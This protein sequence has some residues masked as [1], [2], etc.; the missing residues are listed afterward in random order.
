MTD[1]AIAG[2]LSFVLTN[3]TRVIRPQWDN[4]KAFSTFVV[5]LSILLLL[6]WGAEKWD[7]AN[8]VWDAVVRLFTGLMV[9]LGVFKSNQMKD[10]AKADNPT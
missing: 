8:L 10:E 2:M 5:V 9:G 6:G 7:V 3:I 4:V 1:E